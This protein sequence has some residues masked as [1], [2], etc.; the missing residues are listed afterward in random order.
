M[1]QRNF[2]FKY[3]DKAGCEGWTWL[4][5]TSADYPNHCLVFSSIG[6]VENY[7]NCVREGTIFL[8][9][10]QNFIFQWPSELSVQ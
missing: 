8:V 10:F 9:S 2:F 6:D 4:S 7:P 1:T 5:E 3:Q